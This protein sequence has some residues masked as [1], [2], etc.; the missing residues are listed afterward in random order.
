MTPAGK[1]GRRSYIAA[2]VTL[3]VLSLVAGFAFAGTG[4]ESAPPNEAREHAAAVAAVRIALGGPDVA[5]SSEPVE[6]PDATP[7]QLIAGADHVGAAV[8]ATRIRVP[9]VGID[10]EVRTVGYTFEQ[11]A[12]QYDT[13]RHEAGHYVGSAAPGE[14]GNAVIAGHVA[15]RSGTAVFQQ[16]PDVDVGAVIE[17]YRGETVYRYLV[18]ELRVVPP[19]E[20]EVMAATGDATLTLITCFPDRNYED[21][22]IVVGKLI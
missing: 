7:Q 21:R 4:R 15:A 3:V 18:T 20:I 10:A 19:D 12:L 6:A 17:V 1:Q 22:L 5:P 8:A 2:S 9:S 16:L 13:P 14:P 11:G